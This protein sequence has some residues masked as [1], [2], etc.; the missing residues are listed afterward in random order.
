MKT[1]SIRIRLTLWYTAL[2]SVIVMVLGI[3]VYY[4]ASRG[5]RRVADQELTSGIDGVETFLHHKLAIHE[6][7]NLGEELREH[8][9]LLPR[10]KMFRVT[11]GAGS[12]VYQPDAM[13]V[14]TSFSPSAG[15]M[16]KENVLV[17]SRSFRAISRYATVGPYRFLLEVAVDQTEYQRLMTGLGW[18]LVLSIPLAGLL[19]AFAGY[20]M[21]GRV[22]APIQQITQTAQSIDAS[23]L[24]V[25]LPLMGTG[26]ELDRLSSTI[27]HMLDRI[28]TSY[29][30]ISQFTAD[31]SHELRSPIARLK[32]TTELLLMSLEDRARI[33]SGLL[34]ILSESDYMARLVR[35]LL[36][37]ARNG[38]EEGQV[39]IELFELGESVNAILPRARSLASVRGIDVELITDGSILPL[40]GNQ[41]VVERTLMI[42]IDNAVHYTPQGGSLWITTWSTESF[43]GFTVRDNGVGIAVADQ[44]QI[45]ERF[46][47]VDTV[48]TPGDGGSG[49]GLSIAKS[50]VELHGGRIYLDSKVGVG[51]TFEVS[52]PRANLD[53]AVSEVQMAI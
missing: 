38:L 8:S 17:G 19:S 16:H 27:N 47:R 40:K 15:K 49:L 3:G 6:M 2:V 9:A 33:N 37:L 44:Q 35:D 32:A 36:T 43:C 25:R 51:S 14:V 22:L 52:F 53:S 34:D 29:D 50:L 45:F 20:W 12:V 7:N 42:L 48:R 23:S 10:G 13:T 1:V 11:D 30:R 31:A 4:G 5:L 39:Q 18:L 26:D 28:A 21:S 46:Y 41:S 24:H